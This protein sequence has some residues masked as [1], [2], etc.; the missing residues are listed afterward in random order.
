MAG[1]VMVRDWIEGRFKALVSHVESWFSNMEVISADGSGNAHDPR[2]FELCLA[3]VRNDRRKSISANLEQLPAPMIAALWKSAVQGLPIPQ[4]L[5]AQALARFRA[6]LIADAPFNHARMGLIKSYF[7]RRN[8]GGDATMTASS[9]RTTP[10]LRITAAAFSPC[11]PISSVPR[12]AMLALA[13]Y[14]VSICRQ[15]NARTYPWAAGRQCPTSSGQAQTG[16]R[17]V[18][19]GTH[20]GN[21]EQIGRCRTAH[22]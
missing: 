12:W 6:D 16:T 20:D 7:I 4:P 9:I 17:L 13:L 8:L 2:F 1:R 3:L 11:W 14:N 5:M 15:S 10:P 21:H 18:A 19:R 22:S